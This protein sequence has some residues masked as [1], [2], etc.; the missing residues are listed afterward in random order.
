M[1]IKPYKTTQPIGMLV[2]ET[3]RP[4]MLDDFCAK[5]KKC[6][7][8]ALKND[9]ILHCNNPLA[10]CQM[11]VHPRPKA[12]WYYLMPKH[13]EKTCHYLPMVKSFFY[14]HHPNSM[15]PKIDNIDSY[16]TT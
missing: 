11:W 7:L 5:V 15:V 9:H 12:S 3:K 16:S 14:G 13:I 1:Q 10:Y 2:I 6:P 8:H 4:L